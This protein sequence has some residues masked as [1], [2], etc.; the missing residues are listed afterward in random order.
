VAGVTRDG[1][2]SELRLKLEDDED[3]LGRTCVESY[4]PSHRI[5]GT[6]GG[7]KSRYIMLVRM[8]SASLRKS[9]EGVSMI[10]VWLQ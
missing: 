1:M 7:S 2:L 10:F 6:C 3:A 5:R 9:R 8:L 4:E